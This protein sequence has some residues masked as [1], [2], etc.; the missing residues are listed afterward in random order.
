MIVLENQTCLPDSIFDRAYIVLIGL[1]SFAGQV[2]L[3]YL[4]KIESNLR[5]STRGHSRITSAKRWVGQE[6]AI[7]ADL[8]YSKVS[9]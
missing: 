5:L 6:M 3:V 7:F 1:L 2:T 8:Q 4:A 9:I